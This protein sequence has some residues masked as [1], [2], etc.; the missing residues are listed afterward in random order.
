LEDSFKMSKP[1]G[2]R[3]CRDSQSAVT[4]LSKA[5]KGFHLGTYIIKEKVSLK[6]TVVTQGSFDFRIISQQKKGRLRR[7]F[8]IPSTMETVL[9]I[10][11][12]SL[13]VRKGS[14]FRKYTYQD[15]REPQINYLRENELNQILCDVTDLVVAIKQNG[16]IQI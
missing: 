13:S 14:V 9:R 16:V 10:D 3:E 1:I 4:E 6:Y 7:F 5:L 12:K 15:G 2:N 11:S 8:G